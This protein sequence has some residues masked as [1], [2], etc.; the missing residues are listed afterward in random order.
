M[1]DKVREQ[2]TRVQ[3]LRRAL[4]LQQESLEKGLKELEEKIRINRETIE[5]INVE[6][7]KVKSILDVNN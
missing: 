7:E 6:Y 4:M 2:L 1:E 3:K 5:S